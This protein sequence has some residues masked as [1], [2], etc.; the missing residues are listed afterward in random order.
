MGLILRSSSGLLMPFMAWNSSAP[1][2]N[3][4]SFLLSVP[5]KTTT[6]Q[7]MLAANWMAR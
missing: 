2:F 1:S 4:S 6:S 7:P 5:L 3:A